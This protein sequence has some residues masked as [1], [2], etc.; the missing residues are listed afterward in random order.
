[1]IRSK[2]QAE[3]GLGW[4]IKQME[5]F[6]AQLTIGEI[7][8]VVAPSWPGA[9]QLEWLLPGWAFVTQESRTADFEAEGPNGAC[10]RFFDKTD[11]EHAVL[12]IRVEADPPH[13][14]KDLWLDT[15]LPFGS[16]IRRI[17]EEDLQ[18]LKAIMAEVPILLGNR[19]VQVD[20]GT[21]LKDRLA[22]M[23][24]EQEVLIVEVGG[25]PVG[26]EGLNYYVARLGGENLTLAYAHH[27]RILKEHRGATTGALY[28]ELY[29]ASGQVADV[30]YGWSHEE[31]E[32]IWSAWPS[33]WS[34]RP[35]RAV[36]KCEE[37][38]RPGVSKPVSSGD[39]ETICSFINDTH[40]NE[41]LFN[42]YT[43]ASLSERLSRAPDA[44]NWSSLNKNDNAVLG[45]WK[46]GEIRSFKTGDRVESVKRALALDWGFNGLN[47]EV[48][49]EGLIRSVCGE[50][51]DEGIDEISIFSCEPSPGAELIRSLAAYIEPYV[52][53]WGS[54]QVG[55]PQDTSSRGV[56]VDQARF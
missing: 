29:R 51:I 26:V 9:H 37:L 12:H 17:K 46:A 22:L 41:I 39:S 32:R 18:P 56:F 1:M 8:K 7:K 43:P 11:T 27:L 4:A 42:P 45:L 30:I 5:N 53:C 44:Y 20:P 10:C 25:E 6:G 2:A 28:S 36:L 50:L 3:A 24:G 55:E 15:V 13:R 49:L 31:N 19:K 33:H 40:G 48:D 21:S 14:I 35:F 54:R 38:A 16:R 52:L 34:T 23:G 47:G